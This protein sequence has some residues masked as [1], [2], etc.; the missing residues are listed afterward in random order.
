MCSKCLFY[1]PVAFFFCT[2]LLRMHV[3]PSCLAFLLYLPNACPTC[4]SR[5]PSELAYSKCPSYLPV[6]H[7][8]VLACSECLSYLPVAFF[9]CTCLLRM[10]VFPS[11]LAFLLS[12]PASNACPT[13][14]TCLPSL[15]ACFECLP[16][17][18]DMPSFFTCLLMSYLPVARFSLLACSECLS[19]LYLPVPP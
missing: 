7:S 13:C 4:L 15:P 1:M 11:C 6:A 12:L 5:L 19:Y 2:C 18:P 14:L 17:L 3:L 9:L 10:H 16:Y 8:S